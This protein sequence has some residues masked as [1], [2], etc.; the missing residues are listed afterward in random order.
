MLQHL[1]LQLVEE[2][3]KRVE[4][5]REKEAL[6][7]QVSVLT[8]ILAENQAMDDEDYQFYNEDDQGLRGEHHDQS[9]VY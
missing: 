6:Q 1:Q 4:A 3:R 9:A 5:E 7:E 8:N 2:K